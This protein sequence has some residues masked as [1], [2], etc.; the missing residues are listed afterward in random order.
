MPNTSLGRRR[1]GDARR[2]IRA[3]ASAAAPPAVCTIVAMA[4]D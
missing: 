1:A 3:A 2:S 4:Y